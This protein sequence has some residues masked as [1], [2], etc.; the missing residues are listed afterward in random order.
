VVALKGKGK[1]LIAA[2]LAVVGIFGAIVWAGVAKENKLSSVALFALEACN[3]CT[4]TKQE[5][6]RIKKEYPQLKYLEYPIDTQS[7]VANRYGVKTHPSLL[8]LNQDGL[9]IGRIEKR[10]DYATIKAKITGLFAKAP[11]PLALPD[12]KQSQP[13]SVLYT[14]YLVSTDSG[15]YQAV[16][17]FVPQK[18]QV[19]FDKINAVTHLLA[20]RNDLPS[21]LTNPIPAEVKLLRSISEG[22]VS[23]VLLSED[24]GRNPDGRIRERAA[25]LI[26]NTMFELKDV[27]KVQVR[28]GDYASPIYIGKIGPLSNNREYAPNIVVHTAPAKGIREYNANILHGKE[29]AYLPC[30]CGCGSVGHK[31]NFNCFFKK[32]EDGSLYTDLHGENCE[33]CLE[34]TRSYLKQKAAGKSLPEIRDNVEKQYSGSKPTDTPKP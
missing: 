5:L 9:E 23:V 4:Q 24:L 13:G 12:A 3:G 19:N 29:I 1:W 18:S 11:A 10:T 8:F 17:Q 2:V 7:D 34:I 22:D 6:D 21:N 33:T 26:A 15:E 25:Q 16:K 14:F 32:F 27:Q 20:L 31:S 30:Y 28:S